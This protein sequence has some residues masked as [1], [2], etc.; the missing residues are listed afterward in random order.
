[1]GA[2]LFA[3]ETMPASATT[4]TSSSRSASW[5]RVIIG[6]IVWVYAELPANAPHMQWK[7]GGISKQPDKV[8]WLHT[9]F[10][11]K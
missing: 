9:A 5:N 1:M 11:G 2:C 4:E 6:S 10:F 3:A 8:L 7:T